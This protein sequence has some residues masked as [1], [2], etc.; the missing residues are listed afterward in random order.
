MDMQ[1]QMELLMGGGGSS[2]S[3][4]QDRGTHN[5]KQHIFWI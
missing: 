2:G 4:S 3:E 5:A 1:A